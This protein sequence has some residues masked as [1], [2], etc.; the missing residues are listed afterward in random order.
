MDNQLTKKEDK[1]L[2][3]DN[4]LRVGLEGINAK[5]LPIPRLVLAQKSSTKTFLADG[6]LAKPGTFYLSSTQESLAKVDCTFVLARTREVVKFNSRKKM[7][8]NLT[9]DDYEKAFSFLGVME[10]DFK[11]FLFECR[12]SSAGAARAFLGIVM[13][14]TD[15]K[16][17]QYKISLESRFVEGEKGSWYVVAFKQAGIRPP[18]EE[19]DNLIKIAQKY[20]GDKAPLPEEEEEE[21]VNPKVKAFDE[22]KKKEEI[23][24]DEIPF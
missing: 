1:P 5:D 19:L 9:A 7:K 14:Q 10:E 12:S 6:S 23:T 20:T 21:E 16:L 11:P 15:N 13:S 18:G 2:A 4:N 24:P 3:T 22:E 17:Q 8:E